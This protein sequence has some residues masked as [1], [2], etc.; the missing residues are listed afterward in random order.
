MTLAAS[1]PV[2]AKIRIII[3][4][5]K[6]GL[7]GR[8]GWVPVGARMVEVD[9]RSV[10]VGVPFAEQPPISTWGQYERER[11]TTQSYLAWDAETDF[12]S[13]ADLLVRHGPNALTL[14]LGVT[15]CTIDT[16]PATHVSV[17]KNGVFTFECDGKEVTTESFTNREVRL[18]DDA[19]NTL[20][21]KFRELSG[22]ELK[23]VPEIKNWYVEATA[24]E[25][26]SA[27]GEDE[28]AAAGGGGG[29]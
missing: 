6:P 16:R 2:P 9:E 5:M 19:F 20:V 28:G 23:S 12:E 10:E 8:Q 27:E 25:A 14:L 17:G 22:K 11:V 4:T 1:I 24:A 26:T 3:E 29:D 21:Q 13:V 7:Q 18:T 15:K